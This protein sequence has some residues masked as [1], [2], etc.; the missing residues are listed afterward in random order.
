MRDEGGFVDEGHQQEENIS[1]IVEELVEKGNWTYLRT[2]LVDLH[3]ADIAEAMMRLDRDAVLRVF[4]LLDTDGMAE[5]LVELDTHAR[6]DILRELEEGMVVKVIG[7]MESDDA[8]DVIG[9]LEEEIAQRVLNALPWEEFREVKTLLRHDEET[10]GGIMAMEIVAVNQERTAQDAMRVLRRK[11]EEVEDV[12]NIYVIDDQR[13]LKGVVSLKDLVLARPNTRLS[14]IMDRESVSIHPEMDQEQVANLFH[15]YDLVAAPVVDMEGRLVG[16]ITVDDV[17]DVVEDEVSE[18]MTKMAGITDEELGE[19]SIFKISSVRLPWLLVAFI[20][21]IVSAKVYEHFVPSSNAIIKATFF[22]PMIMAMAGNISIQS[23]TVVIRGLITGDIRLKD[24]G[25]RLI[26]E[27]SV[28]LI[29][30]LII[31]ML[32]FGIVSFFFDPR[33][34]GVISVA[35]I[36]VLIL[37]ASI[38]TL[39]PIILKRVNVDPAIAT[40]PFITTSN[41]IIG[42]IIYFSIVRMALG[43]L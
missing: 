17:M 31:A 21:Q 30:G 26:Q 1:A 18:D 20:G 23:S 16:R 5:V 8:T 11:A 24:T 4:K 35:L 33:F 29:N 34:G 40:G 9:E 13:V 43:G 3:P 38:G 41:D 25:W 15:K 32:L 36:I 2:I 12:Y 22:V 7:A 10:A 37:A 6:Q 42:L 39:I 14:K 19:R 27:L 28:T